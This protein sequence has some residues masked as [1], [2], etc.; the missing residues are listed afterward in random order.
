MDGAGDPQEGG[1]CFRPGNRRAVGEIFALI[2]V[3]RT[4][5]PVAV[6]CQHLGGEPHQ[7][8]RLGSVA[9]S[10][11]ALS[12]AWLT[13]KIRQIPRRLRGHVR[14]QGGSHLGLRLGNQIHGGRKRVER[15]MKAAGISGVAA[16]KRR[17][18]QSGCR[19]SGSLR[20][21][22]PTPAPELTIEELRRL[23][24]PALMEA[25][26]NRPDLRAAPA[27]LEPCPQHDPVSAG[28]ATLR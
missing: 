14:G 7:L 17:A 27:A 6:M 28:Q 25:V 22:Q 19:A 9:P 5:F 18:R 10:D 26:V 12:D 1:R 15:L 24:Q 11:R 21:G 2:E 16:H 4:N 13:E 8:S 23:P 20:T 3:E